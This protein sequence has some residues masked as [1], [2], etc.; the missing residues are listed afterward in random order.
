MAYIPETEINELNDLGLRIK[1][2]K[3]KIRIRIKNPL[4]SIMKIA[5]LPIPGAIKDAVGNIKFKFKRKRRPA[6]APQPAPAQQFV[7][8]QTTTPQPIPQPTTGLKFDKKLLTYGGIGL[9]GLLLTLLLLRSN[10]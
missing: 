3:P 8:Q 4:K 6:F 10:K 7:P 9:G 5:P 2:K 1:I